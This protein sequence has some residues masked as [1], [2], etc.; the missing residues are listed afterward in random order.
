[1]CVCVCVC[2][3]V[4]V[5]V[6]VCVCDSPGCCQRAAHVE[7]ITGVIQPVL[8]FYLCVLNPALPR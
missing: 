4:C 3:F 7:W 2:V 5:C 8:L 6:C 1:M